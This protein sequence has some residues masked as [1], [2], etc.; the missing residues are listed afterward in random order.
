[1]AETTIKLAHTIPATDNTSCELVAVLGIAL[2]INTIVPRN[3][4]QI[5]LGKLMM[6][7]IL[8]KSPMRLIFGR[9]PKEP[10]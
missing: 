3:K 6:R 7:C 5:K 1:M 10:K 9:E 8:P 4:P 2:F